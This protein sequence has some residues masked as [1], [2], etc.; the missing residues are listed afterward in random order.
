MATYKAGDTFNNMKL[1]Q[2]QADRLN[3]Q[4]AQTANTNVSKPVNTPLNFDTSSF[5]TPAKMPSVTPTPTD[6]SVNDLKK[7]STAANQTQNV[8]ANPVAPTKTAAQLAEEDRIAQE[9]VVEQGMKDQNKTGSRYGLTPGPD[10]IQGVVDE[11]KNKQAQEKSALQKQL[12]AQK[13]LDIAAGKKYDE[14]AAGAKAAN[15]A[16]YAQGREGAVAGSAAGMNREFTDAID[17]E[18]GENKIRLQAAQD[19]RDQLMIQLDQAQKDGNSKMAESISKSLAAAKV[20][21]EQTKTNYLNALTSAN[22]QAR[23]AQESTR[24]SMST[25]TGMVDSGVTLDPKSIMA[26][27]K[28]LNVPLEMAMGYYQ[29]ADNVRNDKKLS[30]EEKQVK[31]ADLKSNFELEQA[32]YRTD[33]AKQIKGVTDLVKSG[34]ISQAEASNLMMGLN[35]P[36]SMNPFTQLELK[37]QAADLKA[38]QI[39]LKYLDAEKQQALTMGN[40]QITSNDLDNMIKSAKAQGASEREILELEQLKIDVRKNELE[41]NEYE[42]SFKTELSPKEYTDIFF[43]AGT[44]RSKRSQKGSNIRECGEGYNDITDGPNVGDGFNSGAGNKMSFVTH[45]DSPKVG[46]GVVSSHGGTKNGHMETVISVNP[47]TNAMVLGGW[48]YYGD[49]KWSTRTV[50]VDEMNKKYGSD[51]G[52][53]DSKLKP[54]YAEKLQAADVPKSNGNTYNDYLRQA[55]TQ[56][57]PI[58]EAKSWAS[59]QVQKQLEMGEKSDSNSAAQA[60]F[61]GNTGMTI[62]DIPLAQRAEV[63]AALSK[64]KA[65]ALKSGDT[66]SYLKASAGGRPLD[67]TGAQSMGKAQNVLSQ[68]DGLEST[69]MGMDTGPITGAFRSANPYDVDQAKLKAQLQAIVPNLARGVYGEV[70]VL[71][72]NDIKNYIA[73]LPNGFNTEDQKKALFNFTKKTVSN[74]I[75]NNLKNYAMAG[76]NVSG[77]VPILE[78]LG[79]VKQK[80]EDSPLLAILKNAFNKPTNTSWDMVDTTSGDDILNDFN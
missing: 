9:G 76:Y 80:A 11:F 28:T 10:T 25:F 73:T 57:M 22:E 75:E 53:T 24:Q 19:Q 67:A 78:S 61:E 12:D 69:I 55:Q 23:L 37:N 58:K 1:N 77:Y 44:N 17:K 54:E 4:T 14:Q 46:E 35:I 51:W 40:Q 7:P 52:L 49:G 65:E 30:L 34:K 42:Q 21:I 33:Q 63:S 72:D 48:N 36:S 26:M 56:G 38:K 66:V 45:R 62:D 13:T 71:T 79:G 64:K 29:G 16:A 8:A 70:G 39:G 31:L 60:I 32:G 59:D 18:I 6:W 41:K 43:Q 20:Q 50:T 15:S 68:M 3:S 27:A 47:V 5:K 74:S 2:S